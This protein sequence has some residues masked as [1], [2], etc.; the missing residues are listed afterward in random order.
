[1]SLFAVEIL[2]SIVEI[3]AT[4]LQLLDEHIL[5]VLLLMRDL[6]HVE[7]LKTVVIAV[8]IVFVGT[9]ADIQHT[10]ILTVDVENS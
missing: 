6:N 5:A 1:M 10:H 3:I 8:D 4:F 2:E 9:L 7:V